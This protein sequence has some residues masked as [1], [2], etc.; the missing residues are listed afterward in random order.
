MSEAEAEAAAAVAAV[1]GFDGQ[2]ERGHTPEVAEMLDECAGCI[3][4]AVAGPV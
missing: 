4:V 3:Q 2:E 1:A